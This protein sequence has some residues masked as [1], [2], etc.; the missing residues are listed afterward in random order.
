M[1]GERPGKGGAMR[2][3][4]TCAVTFAISAL[5]L[6]GACAAPPEQP[7]TVA[8][9]E[10]EARAL[11]DW[12]NAQVASPS[13][14]PIRTKIALK[15]VR[16]Q[17]FEML[18]NTTVPD[19]REKVAILEYAKIREEFLRRQDAIE[20]EYRPFYRQAFR[21]AGQA[22]QAALADLYNGASTYGE[23]AKRRQQIWAQFD[24]V[25][26][27]IQRAI[28]E[29]DLAARRAALQ[30][31]RDMETRRQLQNL[32]QVPQRPR[33]TCQRIGDYTFCQ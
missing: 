14:D 31:L 11:G 29:D 27:Q 4:H 2:P 6:L 33:I 10:A 23:F 22:T 32:N 12:F 20:A 3:A 5:A 16:D 17:T 13:L 26:R 1:P 21:V 7:D 30:A 9:F 15:N 18:A 24:D 8:Q 19:G 28:A 25:V